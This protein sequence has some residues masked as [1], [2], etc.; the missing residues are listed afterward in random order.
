VPILRGDNLVGGSASA[1]WRVPTVEV[2]PGVT[3]LTGD[4]QAA[5]ITLRTL[6][7]LATPRH[8]MVRWGPGLRRP[9]TDPGFSARRTYVGPAMI[10]DR[11]L[12]VRDWLRLTVALWGCPDTDGVIRAALN[13]WGLTSYADWRIGALSR[14][15]ERRL[16]LA[17]SLIPMPT[18]WFLEDPALGLD[19]QGRLMLE[20]ILADP[21][22]APPVVVLIVRS[23]ITLP[24]HRMLEVGRD[25]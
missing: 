17:A 15:F 13:R 4:A 1:Q 9:V 16:V 21:H 22:V 11:H 2:F 7:G 18:F 3:V 5:A 12:T 25:H 8:G 10:R 19:H 23:P 6:A 24:P 14:E 20:R